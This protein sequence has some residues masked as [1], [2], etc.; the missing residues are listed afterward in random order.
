MNKLNSITVQRSPSQIFQA[1]CFP[2]LLSIVECVFSCTST[3]SYGIRAGHGID[4]L[5]GPSL[6]FFL[7]FLL[8]FIII[9]LIYTL[10]I[11]TDGPL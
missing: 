6:P 5:Q 7:L 8:L 2:T 9:Y 1:L 4:G 10:P 11:W 3:T